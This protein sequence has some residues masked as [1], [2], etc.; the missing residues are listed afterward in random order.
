MNAPRAPQPVRFLPLLVTAALV[1]F[2]ANSILCR[3]ALASGSIDPFSF[4]ILRVASGALVLLAVLGLR[5][6]RRP[7]AGVDRRRS[8]PDWIAATMLVA[9]LVPFS[10][11]YTQVQAG[12]GTLLLFGAVQ[13]TLILAGLAGGER[14]RAG[15]WWG[16]ALASA[17]LFLLSAPGAQAPPAGGA[18]AMVVAGAAWGFYTVRGRGAGDPVA[19]TASNFVVA[20]P[21]VVAATAAA[22]F[23]SARFHLTLDGVALAVASGALASALGYI[24]WYAAMRALT[25]T[26]AA[27]LQLA[28]PI[29]AAAGGV[30]LLGEPLRARLM[31]AAVTLLAGVALA[32]MAPRP[33]TARRQTSQPP[34]E[35]S[36]AMGSVA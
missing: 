21:L 36:P 4:A 15:Q 33:R 32:T 22:A 6:S 3:A 29:L 10:W 20:T 5:R 7:R 27:V 26:N 25:A 8:T 14:P 2:G 11:A 31:L 23:S 34:Q 24:A 13:S 12:T 16:L 19:A 35:S 28:V 9:Y 1:A 18:V 30:V 17:G